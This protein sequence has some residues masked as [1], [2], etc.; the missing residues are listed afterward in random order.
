MPKSP[1]DTDRIRVCKAIAG[2]CHDL[3]I[4]TIAEGVET[5]AQLE[6]LQAIRIDEGQGFYFAKPMSADKM[7]PLLP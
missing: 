6:L 3:G 5:Q 7:E 2:L 4:T 1:D